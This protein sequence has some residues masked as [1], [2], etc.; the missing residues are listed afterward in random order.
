MIIVNADDTDSVEDI[1]KEKI[2]TSQ[3]EYQETLIFNNAVREIFLNRFVQM[4]STYEH[5]VIQPSQ[6]YIK[7]FWTE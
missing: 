3:E 2:L 4:F 5:F 6:V 7:N 1:T